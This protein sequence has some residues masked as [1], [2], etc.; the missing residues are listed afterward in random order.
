MVLDKLLPYFE[1]V[2]VLLRRTC[3]CH[4]CHCGIQVA[5]V[6]WNKGI[7]QFV[8]SRGQFYRAVTDKCSLLCYAS[9]SLIKGLSHDDSSFVN[10]VYVL[11][12]T[13][14]VLVLW[15][16]IQLVED[17]SCH[18]MHCSVIIQPEQVKQDKS[19]SSACP[20]LT[21]TLLHLSDK[22]MHIFR[23]WWCVRCESELS[24]ESMKPKPIVIMC[25]IVRSCTFTLRR[26]SQE[27]CRISS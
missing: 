15:C 7:E 19:L 2:V 26:P 23:R 22:F 14:R 12:H 21:P 1:V 11:L 27:S 13:D 24:F 8:A 18:T 10:F 20:L 16:L 25:V 9:I 17:I 6:F 5:N 4:V 3:C